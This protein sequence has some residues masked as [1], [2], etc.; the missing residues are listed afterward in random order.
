MYMMPNINVIMQI[1]KEEFDTQAK[2]CLGNDNSKCTIIILYDQSCDKT[3]CQ[4]VVDLL[5]FAI[6]LFKLAVSVM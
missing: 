2:K 4:F 3:L 1:S 5:I 6:T